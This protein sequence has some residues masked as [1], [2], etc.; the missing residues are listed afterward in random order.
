MSK[1]YAKQISPWLKIFLS[2]YCI[3]DFF[4]VAFNLLTI[5]IPLSIVTTHNEHQT[6]D[7]RQ[8]PLF[9]L[10]SYPLIH[11]TCNS[12][13]MRQMVKGIYLSNISCAPEYLGKFLISQRVQNISAYSECKFKDFRARNNCESWGWWWALNLE[14]VS[15]WGLGNMP[16]VSSGD[17]GFMQRLQ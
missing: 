6:R 13:S 14:F 15:H 2:V 16:T 5:Y 11:N 1:I 9:H 8:F 12:K 3:L 4:S 7:L 17:L 10:Q